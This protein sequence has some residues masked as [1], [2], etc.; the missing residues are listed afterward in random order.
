MYRFV[1]YNTRLI[2]CTYIYLFCCN[3]SESGVADSPDGQRQWIDFA[4][5]SAIG[6]CRAYLALGPFIALLACIIR[7][8]GKPVYV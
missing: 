8:I 3:V 4:V 2:R 1:L 5:P 7:K 6:C